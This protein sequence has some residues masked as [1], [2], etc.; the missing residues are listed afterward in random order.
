MVVVSG[1]SGNLQGESVH[2]NVST[3]QG[4]VRCLSD[5]CAL[6]FSFPWQQSFVLGNLFQ[7]FQHHLLSPLTQVIV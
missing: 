5:I 4:S 3:V 1:F 7:E 6:S 2:E